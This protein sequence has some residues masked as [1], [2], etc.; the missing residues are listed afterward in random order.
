M[1]RVLVLFLLVAGIGAAAFSSPFSGRLDVCTT[2]NDSGI[3]AFDTV[4]DVDY[5]IS[6]IVLGATAR[7]LLNDFLALVLTAGGGLGPIE[8]DTMIAF[9]TSAWWIQTRGFMVWWS[10][11]KLDLGGASIFGAFS[12]QVTNHH[13]PVVYGAGAVL[14]L[15]GTVGDVSVLAATYF[16][17][18][19][20]TTLLHDY[21]YEWLPSHLFYERCGSWNWWEP[22]VHD[23]CSLGWDNAAIV[24]DFPLACLDASAWLHM[25]DVGFGEMQ[26]VFRGIETGWSWLAIDEFLIQFGPNATSKSIRLYWDVVLGDLVCVTPYFSLEGDWTQFA[27]IDGITLNALWLEY[28]D[29]GVTVRAGELF[30]N[31]WHPAMV[32]FPFTLWEFSLDGRIVTRS[33]PW[34]PRLDHGC[35]YYSIYDEFIGIWIDGDSCCGGSFDIGLISFFQTADTGNLFDWQETVATLGAD[36]GTNVSITLQ[37]SLETDGLQWLKICGSFGF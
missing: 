21:G 30:D 34:D 27:S 36:I 4:F 20:Y 12:V 9:D 33:D 23:E 35:A 10:A 8:F 2:F 1:R 25:G 11:A 6:G 13:L 18:H 37:M 5:T 24:V 32:G 29:N 15:V 7:F 26:F 3:L 19:A 17:M 22:V 28:S 14:G 31:T 16:N